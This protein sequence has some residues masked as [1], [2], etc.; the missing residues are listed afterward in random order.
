MA[1]P[2]L[3]EIKMFGG[4]FAPRGYLLCNGQL[5]SIAQNTAL[6]SLMGTTYGG[7]GQST[8]GLPNF[9]GVVPM[10]FG[11]G[12][13]LTPRVMGESGGSSDVILT[14]A[15]VPPHTH[16]L[17]GTSAGATTPSP[18]G[19]LWAVSGSRRITVNQYSAAKGTGVAMAPQ[20]LA[21]AGLSVPHNNLQP[22]LVVN[23]IMATQGIYPSR[24]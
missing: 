7:N 16:V 2:F 23:F 9:Q 19:N 12:P 21:T 17:N 18:S 5:L 1:E 11:N 15:N 22:T 3:G 13:G 4:N 10:G 8:F 6:F 20:A 14:S 24:N